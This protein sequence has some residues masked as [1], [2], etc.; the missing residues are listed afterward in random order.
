MNQNAPSKNRGWTLLIDVAPLE[1]LIEDRRLLMLV[2]IGVQSISHRL[3][4]LSPMACR[5]VG[6]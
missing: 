1:P 6:R 4:Q 3:K 5:K 2:P